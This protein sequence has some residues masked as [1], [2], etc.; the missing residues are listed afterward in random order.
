MIL[1]TIAFMSPEQTRGEPLD[2]RSD[3]F[4]LGSVLYLAATG[5]LPFSGG[6]R[7]FHHA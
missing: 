1:G 4:S 5:R 3:V 7:T 6:E 2:G